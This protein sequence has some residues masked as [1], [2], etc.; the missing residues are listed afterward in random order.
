MPNRVALFI[1]GAY[2]ESVLWQEFNG[3]RVD[4]HALSQAMAKESDILRTYYY[5]CL[6]YRSNNPTI[7]ENDRYA[8]RSRFYNSLENLPRYTVRLGELEYRGQNPDRTPRFEQKRVDV[9]LSL[10]LAL[11]SSKGQIQQAILLAGDSDFIPAVTAAKQE[12]VLVTLFHGA[13]YHSDLWREADERFRIDQ[14]LI[15]S[16]TLPLR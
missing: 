1:D 12:G 16:V 3:R 6:P 5:N 8:R 15:D 13:N 11:L 10:D 2:A 7:S 9:L 4:F 14:A